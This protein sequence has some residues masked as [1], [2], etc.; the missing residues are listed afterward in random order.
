MDNLHNRQI[1][2][3]GNINK[4]PGKN[5]SKVVIKNSEIWSKNVLSCSL[6]KFVNFLI[7]VLRDVT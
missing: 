5:L 4:I 1:F 3:L 6:I 2:D 7:I